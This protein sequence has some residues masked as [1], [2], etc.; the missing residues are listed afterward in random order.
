MNWFTNK[1]EKPVLDGKIGNWVTCQYRWF[2]NDNYSSY[3]RRANKPWRGSC[4]VDL[5]QWWDRNIALFPGPLPASHR[6]QYSNHTASDGKLPYCKWRE[7]TVLQAT[8]SWA[9]A[10]EKHLLVKTWCFRTTSGWQRSRRWKISIEHG[11][12]L[13]LMKF[14]FHPS[15]YQGVGQKKFGGLQPLPDPP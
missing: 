5:L 6:L 9:R 4:I 2:L 7:A 1:H 10:W 15:I 13:E 8:G 11:Y 12:C 3:L 14:L